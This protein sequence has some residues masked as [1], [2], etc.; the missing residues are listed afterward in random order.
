MNR[1]YQLHDETVKNLIALLS[2]EADRAQVLGD[3]ER[4]S[5]L[6]ADLGALEAQLPQ[7]AWEYEVA[8]Q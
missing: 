2:H 5:N 7:E 4:H 8:T 1:N 6:M 3:D